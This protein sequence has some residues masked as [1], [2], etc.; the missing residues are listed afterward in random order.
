MKSA[1]KHAMVSYRV[2][3]KVT[4]LVRMRVKI[5]MFNK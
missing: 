1:T 4:N 2:W 3:Y 5:L